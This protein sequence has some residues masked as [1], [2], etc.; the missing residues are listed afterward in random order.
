MPSRQEELVKLFKDNISVYEKL[1]EIVAKL[2]VSIVDSENIEC[3][4]PISS[5][6]KNVSSFL[7]KVDRK[8]YKDPLTEMTDITGLR[9]VLHSEDDINFVKEIIQERFRV[10]TER[11]IDKKEQLGT[12]QFGYSGINYVV[13]LSDNDPILA[14]YADFRGKF[15][16]IQV[17]TLCQ[18]VYSEIQRK[19][20]YKVEDM[21]SYM[22]SRRLAMLCALFELAD[23][24][25]RYLMEKGVEELLLMPITLRSL[26]IYIYKSKNIKKFFSK[27]LKKG[28]VDKAPPEE[29]IAFLNELYDACKFAKLKAVSDVDLTVSNAELAQH[30]F[31]SI[32][33]HSM[34]I[35]SGPTLLALLLLY[36][37]NGNINAQFLLN[38]NWDKN[39]IDFIVDRD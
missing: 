30:L 31:T 12:N 34:N 26:R 11:S 23:A 1:T 3:A 25:F 18:L 2:L 33:K 16:E 7:E 24:E 39:S 32:R 36:H 9:I 20:E 8:K 10:D 27:A 28:F 5:R 37:L 6:T 21:V 13:S 19:I 15:F 29:D 35:R 4:F 14:E 22:I 17:L 38:K